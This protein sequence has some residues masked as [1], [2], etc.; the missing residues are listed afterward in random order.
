MV[1]IKG[2]IIVKWDAIINSSP[3]FNGVLVDTP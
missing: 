2:Y 3:N 1:Q